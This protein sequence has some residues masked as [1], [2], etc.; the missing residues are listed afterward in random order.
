[1]L[2]DLYATNSNLGIEKVCK[3]ISDAI[4]ELKQYKLAIKNTS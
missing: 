1:M 2:A 3:H 4:I